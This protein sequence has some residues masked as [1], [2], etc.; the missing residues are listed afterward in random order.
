MLPGVSFVMAFFPMQPERAA[1]AAPPFLTAFFA[2][3]ADAEDFADILPD[4]VPF[5]VG[6]HFTALAFG[7]F[8]SA[9]AT[10]Y[11]RAALASRSDGSS[12]SSDQPDGSRA[13]SIS[14]RNSCGSVAS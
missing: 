2:V 10:S 4:R 1:Y 6:A 3:L 11:R 9:N 12:T 7:L 13:N 8:F 5:A 14:M